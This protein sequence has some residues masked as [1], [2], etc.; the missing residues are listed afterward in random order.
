MARD[1]HAGFLGRLRV[2]R[3][4]AHALEVTAYTNC[5]DR[6]RKAIRTTVVMTRTNEEKEVTRRH[7]L[8]ILA[9]VSAALALGCSGTTEASE[10]S[11]GDAGAGTDGAAGSDASTGTDGGE[12]AVT[13]EGEIGPYFSD[14]SDSRFNRTNIT[15]NLDGSNIQEG[16]PFTLTITVIDVDAGCV[17]YANAQ[18]DIWH[19]NT[20]G[21][22]SDQAAESTTTEQW[23]RGYQMT[24]AKGQVTFNTVIPGWY[25]GRATHIHLR[26]R[27]TYSTA[28]STSDG[29]NTTQLFFDQT[30]I[31][32]LDTTVTPYSAE[33]KNNTTNAG[34]HVFSGETKGAN[35]LS[36]VG[37]DTSGYVASVTI[38]IPI[39]S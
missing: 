24:D 36:L 18:V 20:A 19:C 6:F 27:S 5:N 9:S 11:S 10:S 22:Y 23:L 31:D 7:A 35:L 13:P 3:L 17:P 30:F 34:D 8:G 33:G 37:N 28:S 21:I 25:Q 32:T 16:I 1:R 14:D 2:A 29:T 39:A 4:L 26:V 15:A 12:C 38:G